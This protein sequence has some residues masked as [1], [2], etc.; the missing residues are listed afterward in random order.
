MLFENPLLPVLN[1]CLQMQPRSVTLTKWS[2]YLQNASGNPK[3]TWNAPLN[4]IAGKRYSPHFCLTS[5]SKTYFYCFQQTG[6]HKGFSNRVSFFA[7]QFQ[8]RLHNDACVLRENF[9][10]DV[11]DVSTLL[12]AVGRILNLFWH[13]MPSP[14]RRFHRQSTESLYNTTLRFFC[15]VLEGCL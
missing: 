5:F 14:F 2:V 6:F 4:S 10:Q 8:V 11:S 1:I 9:R 7:W 12:H 3:H 13:E 15:E